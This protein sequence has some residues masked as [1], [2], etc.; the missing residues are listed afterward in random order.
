MRKKSVH[1][2][3]GQNIGNESEAIRQVLEYFGARVRRTQLGRPNDLVQ[4]LAENVD[5]FVILCVHGNNGK[6]Q[7]PELDANLY[8][9]GEPTGPVGE[10]NLQA[11]KVC[12]CELLISSG[13]GLF[14]DGW[15]TMWL[16]KGVQNFIGARKEVA[17]NS[18]LQFV[19]RVF[20]EIIHNEESV[21]DAF[22]RA[23][24]IDDESALFAHSMSSV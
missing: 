17:G 18:A 20:Y 16:E 23:Q 22:E 12:A 2:I 13:C 21:P 9:P 4:A 10:R 3:D 1:I 14:T 7:L 15:A 6:I 8:L 24:L 11:L 19:L 5:D